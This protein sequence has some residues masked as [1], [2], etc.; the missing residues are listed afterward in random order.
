MKLT[1]AIALR[2]AQLSGAGVGAA[3]LADAIEVIRAAPTQ[4]PPRAK[5]PKWSAVKPDPW[6]LSVRHREIVSRL[7][8]CRTNADIGKELGLADIT[9]RVHLIDA[10]KRMGVDN[11]TQAAVLWDRWVR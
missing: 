3:Q 7:F 8:C 9:V 5:R 6:G 1:D 4:K 11:R 10:F 2:Q